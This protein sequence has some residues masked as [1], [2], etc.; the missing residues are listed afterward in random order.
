MTS[1]HT[2]LA[3]AGAPITPEM[4]ETINANK[5]GLLIKTYGS[6]N[7]AYVACYRL[8]RDPLN[9]G[10]AFHAERLQDGSWGVFTGPSTPGAVTRG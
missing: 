7:S 2:P 4:W 8:R 10:V 9:D 1:R 6:D 5:L 3:S